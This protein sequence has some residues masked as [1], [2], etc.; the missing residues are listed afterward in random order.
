M[1]ND[2]YF[3]SVLLVFIFY[4]PT[5]ILLDQISYKWIYVSVAL[6]LTYRMQ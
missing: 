2:Y 4:L 6:D 5:Y 1:K 3:F